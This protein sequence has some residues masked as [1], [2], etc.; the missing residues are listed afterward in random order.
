MNLAMAGQETAGIRAQNCT[1][2]TKEERVVMKAEKAVE[3][4]ILPDNM[5]KPLSKNPIQCFTHEQPLASKPEDPQLTDHPY[6]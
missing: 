4:N 2:A 5:E 6:A 1:V 3:C